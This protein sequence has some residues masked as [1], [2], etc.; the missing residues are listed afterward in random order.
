MLWSLD[1]DEGVGDGRT[2]VL[3]LV[4]VS[5]RSSAQRCAMQ[6]MEAGVFGSSAVPRQSSWPCIASAL[7]GA[8]CSS[9]SGTGGYT[10]GGMTPDTHGRPHG[11]RHQG[12]PSPHDEALQ[13]MTLL[14]AFGKTSGRYPKDT[15]RS[16]RI[17]MIPKFL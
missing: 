4:F 9:L 11:L 15:T 12:R 7:A 5:L 16:V 13:G 8:W 17:H 10:M 1:S 14:G 3:L 2:M 6:R